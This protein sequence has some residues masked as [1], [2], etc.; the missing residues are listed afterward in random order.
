MSDGLSQRGGAV[1]A[2][3]CDGGCLAGRSIGHDK[4]WNARAKGGGREGHRARHRA[5]RAIQPQLPHHRGV[6]QAVDVAQLAR[7][8]QDPH[9]DRQV[10]AGAVLG[11]VCRGEVV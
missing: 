1:D 8:G 3:A 4:R 2:Q 10:V 11:Q 9:R 5:H 6:A 7:C